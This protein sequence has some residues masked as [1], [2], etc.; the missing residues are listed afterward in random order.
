MSDPDGASST[1]ASTN[2]AISDDTL[3]KRV[4]KGVLDTPCPLVFAD[5]LPMLEKVLLL[6]IM[7]CC[8]SLMFAGVAVR[9]AVQAGIVQQH[10]MLLVVKY[11]FLESQF[12][13]NSRALPRALFR[14]DSLC[15]QYKDVERQL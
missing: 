3:T 1:R 11:S 12:D 5:V 9:V 4:A 6:S 14:T 2:A 15:S 7:C 10:E 8:F 13:N